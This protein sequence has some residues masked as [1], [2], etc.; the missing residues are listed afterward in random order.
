MVYFYMLGEGRPAG[1]HFA[2]DVTEMRALFRVS[3]VVGQ[4]GMRLSKN[5]I[6]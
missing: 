2:A 5:L 6:T 4:Q 1:I 3:G